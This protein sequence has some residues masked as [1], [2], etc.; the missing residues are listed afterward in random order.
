M[1]NGCSLSIYFFFFPEHCQLCFGQL[2]VQLLP[3][4]RHGGVRR[5]CGRKILRTVLRLRRGLQCGKDERPEGVL[6]LR[7]KGLAQGPERVLTIHIS[8]GTPVSNKR[9]ALSAQRLA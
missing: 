4:V 5:S 9:L 7:G 3:T 1:S 2:S 6:F 8:A